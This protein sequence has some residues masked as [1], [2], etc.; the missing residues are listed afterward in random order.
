MAARRASMAKMDDEKNAAAILAR[1]EA[2]AAA[3]EA[4]QPLVEEVIEPVSK[5]N[6]DVKVSD[7]LPSVQENCV[8]ICNTQLQ[9]A[10]NDGGEDARSG[11]FSVAARAIKIEL[12]KV[13]GGVWHVVVGKNFGSEV[14]HEDGNFIYFY[15]RNTGFMIWKA[16]MLSS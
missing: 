7:M 3:E 12:D 6:L 11:H 15:L 16:G 14:I 13:N 4:G 8:S 10:I 2:M 5:G 1:E 9:H